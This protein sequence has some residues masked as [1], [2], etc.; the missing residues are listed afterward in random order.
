[1]RPRRLFPGVIVLLALTAALSVV[2]LSS[3]PAWADA[4]DAAIFFEEL[5]P[6]GNWYEDPDYGPAWYPTKDP[7][8]PDKV[9]DASFRPYLDGRWNLTEQGFVFETDESWGWATYHYGNWAL[10]SQGRWVWVPG[11][12]WYP[13]TVNFKTSE[14]YVGWAP[15]PPQTK[16][17]LAI[18]EEPAAAGRACG[19]GS[20]SGTTAAA[21]DGARWRLCP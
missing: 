19:T 4:E 17:A 21:S 3:P 7:N 11:R 1:M 9:Y 5:Q 6:M 18:T 8:K 2:A 12:T 14:D 16:K 10:D 20:R 13:N 15:V